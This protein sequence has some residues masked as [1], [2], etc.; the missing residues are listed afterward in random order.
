MLIIPE[1]V[2]LVVNLYRQTLYTPSLQHHARTHARTHE[3]TNA[4]THA[5]T[6][7][8]THSFSLVVFASLLTIFYIDNIHTHVIFLILGRKKRPGEKSAYSVFNRG[9]EQIQGTFSADDIDRQYRT[10]SLR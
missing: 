8:C 6:N 2:D 10:G 1:L 5:S 3:R 7:V 4:R 9:V